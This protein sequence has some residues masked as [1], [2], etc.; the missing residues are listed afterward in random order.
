MDRKKIAEKVSN[1]VLYSEDLM[2][3]RV[4]GDFMAKL[5]KHLEEHKFTEDD[6]DNPNPKGNDR[7]GDGKTNEKKPDWAKDKKSK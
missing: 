1:H 7:D 2:A 3:D 6:P 5:P 4:A